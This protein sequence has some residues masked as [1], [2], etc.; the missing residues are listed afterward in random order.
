MVGVVIGD[1]EVKYGLETPIDGVVGNE[2]YVPKSSV[3]HNSFL[4]LTVFHGAKST[5]ALGIYAE[6]P[7]V[8]HSFDCVND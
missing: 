5:N 8:R 1:A 2:G 4:F 6:R 7:Y 3:Q